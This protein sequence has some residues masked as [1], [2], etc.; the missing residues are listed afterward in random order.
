[1][2]HRSR[3][4][5]WPA[6]GALLT[7]IAS[8]IGAGTVAANNSA[9]PADTVRI[10]YTANLAYLDPAQAY[11]DD[12]W[13]INGTLY[14]GLYTFDRN[15]RPQLGLAA[16]PPVISA[17][18]KTWTFT[19]RSDARFS[20]GMPVTADDIKFSI[21]RSLDPHL[22]PAVS[23][24]QAFDAPIFVGAQDFAAGKTKDVPGIQVLDSHTIRFQLT[25]PDP[26]LPYLLALTFNMALPRAVVSKETPDNVSLH[27][28]G[29]GPYMLQSWKRG[30]EA[31][32][33]RN[34]YYFNKDKVRI[35]RIV[36]DENV[37]SSVITLRIQKGELDGFGN[38][39]EIAASDIQQVMHDPKYAKYITTAPSAVA[40]YLDLNVHAAPLDNLK[41][42]QAIAMA[43]NRKRL[44]QLLG[45]NA[46][47]AYQM[48]IPLDTQHDAKLD[49]QGGVYPYD[50]QKAAALVK[51]SGY[52]NQPITVLYGND[53]SYYVGMSTGLLQQLQQIGLN[54]NLRG[55]T[56]TSVLSI[57]YK[58]TGHQISLDLWS[59]DYPDGYDIYTGAM[60]CIA[61]AD[62]AI[63]AAHYCD[64]AADK[65]V[66]EAQTK[67]LG[68]ARDALLQ[69]AQRRILQSASRIPLVY[70][71]SVEI[72]SP[73]VGGYYYQPAFG[74]KFEDY[75]L[76]S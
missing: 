21:M 30:S 22:K 24:G 10:A 59:M 60:S 12:W 5:F 7:I 8:T 20:N 63:G 33:V 58:L 3:S 27:P 39:Q 52:H 57:G 56:S 25:G 11:T 2:A 48:Y 65:L 17:D 73:R 49:A 35:A 67:D 55:A 74:W 68:P 50:P 71:K 4:L 41:L 72:V 19:I 1:M 51:E 9:A 42:R 31:I 40:T 76:K 34:P 16:K 43:I 18:K 66:N 37:S 44:V 47:A 64:P 45:G 6:L 36:V 32:L 75:W 38:D 29:S 62:G 53:V 13:L 70:L 54:A 14:N 46:I 69:H 28:V 15:G 23:W 61:N 26:V